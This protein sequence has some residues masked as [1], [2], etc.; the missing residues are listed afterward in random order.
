M[1]QSHI[2]ILTGTKIARRIFKG[3]TVNNPGM[4]SEKLYTGEFRNAKK[5]FENRF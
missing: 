1:C 2:P 4:K 3:R 5:I